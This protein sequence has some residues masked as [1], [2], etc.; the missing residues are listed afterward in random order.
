MAKIQ[1][2]IYEEQC[3]ECNATFRGLTEKQAKSQLSQ[4]KETHEEAEDL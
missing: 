3:P 2:D 4:H 1:G